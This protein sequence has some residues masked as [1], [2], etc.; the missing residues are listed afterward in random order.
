MREMHTIHSCNRCARPCLGRAASPRAHNAQAQ[1]H[2]LRA[3]L[4]ACSAK[5]TRYQTG[6]LLFIPL[7]LG[8]QCCNLGLDL[9]QCVLGRVLHAPRL[10]RAMLHSAVR[11]YMLYQ[12]QLQNGHARCFFCL[13]RPVTLSDVHLSN[14]TKHSILTMLHV[15]QHFR[16]NQQGQVHWPEGQLHAACV[17]PWT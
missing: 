14:D 9:G 12:F 5:P 6:A 15:V 17:S 10:S 16:W 2:V 7:P 3:C 1:I 4:R 11:R 13:R 8:F